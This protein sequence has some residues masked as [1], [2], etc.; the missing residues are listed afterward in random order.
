VYLGDNV[1]VR[2]D[3]IQSSTPFITSDAVWSNGL[4]VLSGSTASYVLRSDNLT[5]DK[6]GNFTKAGAITSTGNSSFSGSVT[7]GSLS[8]TGSLSANSVVA[9]S[10][11]TTTSGTVSTK[12]LSV[13]G[14]KFSV[15][16]LAGTLSL[17][18]TLTSTGVSIAN[19]G[20]T[21]Q[22][23]SSAGT[24]KTQGTIQSAG[25][26][27]TTGTSSITAAGAL[28]GAS[29]NIAGTAFKVDNL[30]AIT[31]SKYSIDKDGNLSQDGTLTTKSSASLANAGFLV[32]TTGNVTKAGTI[33]SK[34]VSVTGSLTTTE[35]IT[36]GTNAVQLSNNGTSSFLNSVTLG[37]ASGSTYPI[38][39]K[40]AD[41]SVSFA[42]GKAAIGADGS[43]TLLNGATLVN[44]DGVKLGVNATNTAN[45]IELNSSS[46]N[47]TFAGQASFLGGAATLTNT[48]L[49]MLGGD[50]SVK[51]ISGTGLLNVGGAATLSSGLTVTGASTFNGAATLSNTL[52]VTGATTLS[53][54]LALT[55]AATLSNTLAVAGVTTLSSTLAVTG[56]ATLSNTLAVTGDLSVNTDKFK[57][58]A[59]SGD[60]MIAGNLRVTGD[61][62]FS[63]S[64][65]QLKSDGS[66]YALNYFKTDFDAYGKND[67]VDDKTITE[68]PGKGTQLYIQKFNSTTNKY[69]TT[70]EYVDNAIF[71]QAARLNLITKDMDVQ[72]A[73]FSNISKVLAAME[74]PDGLNPLT[75]INGLLDN[76]EDVKVSIADLMG[77]GY[78]SVLVNCNPNIWG[79]G[80]APQLIPA[81]ISSVYKEDGWFYSSVSTD[82]YASWNVASYDGMKM[83]D[84]TNL[85]MN[86]FLFS[87]KKLPK[88]SIYTAP[89]NDSSDAINGIYNAK[90]DYYFE[91]NSP[92]APIAQRSCLYVISS[93][94][95]IYSDRSY[96]MRCK[97][98]MTTNGTGSPNKITFTPSTTFLTS[99]DTSKVNINDSILT[100][101]IEA[102]DGLN[103]NDYMYILQNFAV[104][105]TNGTTQFVFQNSAVA[106]N[107]L[108]NKFYKKNIDFSDYDLRD[109]TVSTVNKNNYNAYVASV[110]ANT[111]YPVT[112]STSP[113][114]HV[115]GFRTLSIGGT[116]VTNNS[117][118][119]TFP[120]GTP[121]ALLVCDLENNNNSLVITKN[122]VIIT[123]ANTVGDYSP[124]TPIPLT[125]RDNIFVVT[126]KDKANDHTKVTTFIAKVLSNNTELS[127]VTMNGE[128]ITLVSGAIPANTIKNVLAGTTSVTVVGTPN[129]SASVLVTGATGLVTGNNT[130]TV[131]VTA[132]DGTIANNSFVVRVMSDD[133][134]LSTFTVNS[135][136][137]LNGSSVNLPAGTT[138]VS[139]VAVPTAQSFGATANITGAS[140]LVLGNNTLTVVVT[141][142]SGAIQTY[143][144]TL[145]VLDGN[146]N[147]GSLTINTLP[148]DM[149]TSKFTFA[150]TTTSINVIA[151]AA[152]TSATVAVTGIPNG[153]ELVVPGTTHKLNIKVTAENKASKD[154]EYDV[155][156]QSNDNSIDNIF[157]NSQRLQ[158]DGSN[159][160]DITSVAFTAPDSLSLQVNEASA[161]TLSYT[162]ENDGPVQSITSGDPK[163]V[164]IQQNGTTQIFVTIYPEDTAILSKTY[165]IN[166]KSRSNNT[167]LSAITVT[168]SGGSQSFVTN[169]QTITLASGVT[170]VTV[171]ATA[172]Y[173]GATVSI[174]GEIGTNSSSKTINVPS[175]TSTVVPITVTA[176]DGV[177]QTSYSV[178]IVPPQQLSSDTSLFSLKYTTGTAGNYRDLSPINDN[179]SIPVSYSS[180]NT[181][182]INAQATTD[183]ASI[184]ILD[185]NNAS[186]KNTAA[187]GLA[188]SRVA[189]SAISYSATSGDIVLK[190]KVT[191]QN[192][193]SKIYTIKFLVPTATDNDVALGIA[194]LGYAT[195]AVF[196]QLSDGISFSYVSLPFNNSET[197]PINVE[198]SS[199]SG[200]I[201]KTMYVYKK[202]A[203]INNINVNNSVLG[204]T[205]YY[206]NQV[207]INPTLTTGINK[208]DI[209]VISINL[210]TTHTY[211]FFVKLT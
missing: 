60:T 67:I 59:T 127:S 100:F 70:Q 122:G 176:T 1:V 40:A 89:K 166:V 14:T 178:T 111:L 173:S 128:T 140:G 160:A 37:A 187:T 171:N 46:G 183:V 55:G 25:A 116:L 200:T 196:L 11:F 110:K 42:S 135:T 96:D 12:E 182:K 53:S 133:T 161:A 205:Q 103:I 145:K 48:G 82:S 18:G 68:L 38:M 165:T 118:I 16:S 66:L 149:N 45:K 79:D 41:G 211:T 169:G 58:T 71:K 109:S 125:T 102:T 154:Y 17:T 126:E 80:A 117:Q 69:L 104:S 54:T 147:L 13:A 84:V 95:N 204:V 26:I 120:A 167:G 34:A 155:R 202:N 210:T 179:Q 193:T 56:A 47:A 123:P 86:L 90:I 3:S 184:D 168:P 130:V 32:D 50:V 36:V 190:V 206:G 153:L 107:Y 129:S 170:S 198:A 43:M 4:N 9:T 29:L 209:K 106:T 62:H 85:F 142:E 8:T 197:D 194:T 143:T 191:A 192:G 92:S 83:K 157:V 124:T 141:A 207:V 22:I 35:G 64:Q 146:T 94:K 159:T 23:D 30:G 6:A 97:Y 61:A 99:F 93:P 185:S 189:S 151:T 88:I 138:A 177:T 74:G 27:S 57:V 112:A 134:S 195:G 158:F 19:A 199:L 174:D 180:S 162:I 188:T 24:I 114:S 75:T 105:R 203:A 87:S 163:S 31:G 132:G 164:L 28:N 49:T 137:V 73:T 98:S 76:V 77:G 150:S 52:A 5:I 144:V 115:T 65:I 113:Q 152:S 21:F 108:F 172:S 81:S 39:L 208:I 63:N 131:K 91:A 181:L 119:I 20:S 2:G 139:V 78:N 72:L 51:N 15:D 7:A 44:S 121:S 10:G 148:Q 136:A 33:A 186:V 156:V 201:T 101:S 175:G